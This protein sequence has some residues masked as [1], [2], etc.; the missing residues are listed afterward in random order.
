MTEPRTPAQ[1]HDSSE[2]H[3]QFDAICAAVDDF[4]PLPTVVPGAPEQPP[5]NEQDRWS[6]PLDARILASLVSPV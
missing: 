3:P 1:H 4:Q 5:Q 2:D 6:D